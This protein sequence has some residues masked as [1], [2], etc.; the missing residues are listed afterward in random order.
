MHGMILTSRAGDRPRMGRR[1]RRA[2]EFYG[3]CSVGRSQAPR[4]EI[5]G[6]VVTVPELPDRSRSQ[7]I[8]RPHD[9]RFVMGRDVCARAPCLR[10]E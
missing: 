1:H 6:L 3:P 8:G 2:A 9:E 5:G 4:G 7:I 10:S